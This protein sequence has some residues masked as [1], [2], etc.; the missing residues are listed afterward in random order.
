MWRD[1]P[2]VTEMNIVC[3]G[4]DDDDDDDDGCNNN[5]NNNN[6]IFIQYK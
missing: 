6:N 5:N 3:D 4:Y 1:I 2:T